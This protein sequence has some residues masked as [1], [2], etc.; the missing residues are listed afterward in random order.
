M[1]EVTITVR[2]EHSIRL[3]PERATVRASLRAE[4]PGRVAVVE[5]VAAL[6]ADVRDNLTARRGDGTVDEWSIAQLT[7]W[8]ERPWSDGARLAPVHHAAV[9]VT[10]TFSDFGALSAWASDVAEH[11]GAQV[12]SIEWQ[13]TPQTRAQREQE[14]ASA[15]VRVAVERAEAYARAIGR[16]QVVPIEIADVGL[17]SRGEQ[18]TASFSP[19]LMRAGF[20]GEATAGIELRPEEI[21]LTAAVEARFTAA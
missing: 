3:S 18:A 13:L 8:S 17:L 1:S 16:A 6:T 14:V 11:E 4:G 21:T 7:A 5:R 10:A 12:A 2:G 15:A 19:K 9:E 20:A